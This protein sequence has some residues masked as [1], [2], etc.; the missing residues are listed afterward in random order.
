MAEAFQV[1]LE[2]DH[3]WMEFNNGPL[4]GLPFAEAA[5]RYPKPTFRN[6]YEPFC[7]TGESDWEIHGRAARAVEKIVR[8]GPGQY[9]V[10]AHGGILNAAMRT[11]V[12]APPLLNGHGL[13]LAL[14]DTGYA[15]VIYV[16]ERHQWIIGEVQPEHQT[17]W[18]KEDTL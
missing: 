4:A 3:D 18:H 11:I 2:S 6:P 9:L 12:G 17:Y 16:P 8:R 15:Q 5:A 1:P 7:T 14:G 10:V 13:Y